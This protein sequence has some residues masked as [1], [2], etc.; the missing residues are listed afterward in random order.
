MTVQLFCC[1]TIRKS[2]NLKCV[3]FIH[4][5]ITL[6][7]ESLQLNGLHSGH[8][9]FLHVQLHSCVQFCV[10]LTPGVLIS[11]LAHLQ[12]NIPVSNCTHS[13]INRTTFIYTQESCHFT[14]N[15]GH[16]WVYKRQLMSS[17]VGCQILPH[18]SRRSERR[19]TL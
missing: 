5:H 18:Q 16:E 6:D 15:L 11:N 13:V 4:T 10:T 2:I 19:Q 8:T 1:V 3:N 9:H 12:N 7:Y 14:C 17:E